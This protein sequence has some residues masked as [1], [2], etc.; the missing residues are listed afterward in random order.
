[1]RFF[2]SLLETLGVG[3]GTFFTF[4]LIAIIGLL[5][6]THYEFFIALFRAFGDWVIAQLSKSSILANGTYLS[7]IRRN[8]ATIKE[9]RD[10]QKELEGQKQDLLYDYQ[11]NEVKYRKAIDRASYLKSEGNMAE[12]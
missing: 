1:M 10:L 11:Q 12:H 2:N 9:T 7:M 4:V 5:V 6:I 8:K 3:I